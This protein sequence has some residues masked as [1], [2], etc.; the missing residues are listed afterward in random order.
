MIM[1][2]R[3]TILNNENK[4]M[5]AVAYVRVSTE[6]QVLG[7]SLDSQVTACLEYAERVLK[8]DLPLENIFREEGV[9]AKLID[10]PELAKM[11]NHCAKRK[12]EISHCIVWKVDRLARRSEYH[13]VIKAQLLKV[14]VRLVSVTE[15]ISDDPMGNL[16][17]TVLSGFA[18]FDNEIRLIRTTGGMKARTQQGGW[19]H[20]APFGYRKSRTTTGISSIEPDENSKTAKEFL[21]EFNTGAYTVKQM[22]EI[23]FEMGIRNKKGGKKNWQAIKNILGNPLYAGFVRSKY[24][25]G[26]FI[27][28]VHVALISEAT[29]YKNQAIM[30]G[31]FKNH[32]VQAKEKWPL[33]GGFIKHICGKQLTGS[34]T[35][36]GSGPSPRYTCTQCKATDSMQ[37][38]LLRE[39]V[40]QDFLKLLNSVQPKE[41]TQKLYKEVLLRQWNNEFK[42]ALEASKRVDEELAALKAKKSRILDMFIDG[43]ID[44]SDK[45]LKIR[46]TEEQIGKTKLNQIEREAYV[47]EKEKIV[48]GALL[49]MSDPG[50]FWN[51]ANLDLR[52]HI[53]HTVFPNGVTYDFKNGFQNPVPSE[54][55]L[56]QKEVSKKANLSH[57]HVVAA[58]GFEPVTSGL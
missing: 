2:T 24:T 8:I 4:I 50:L 45:D 34:S 31:Q 19:P 40:H 42:N 15:P 32:S 1:A 38:S 43:E 21:E 33:R 35:R 58:T 11:V 47:D 12:G 46:E 25:D 49:F 3:K 16:M 55:F 26:Q 56:L 44:A 14:G 41:G 9:S 22:T 28:G 10:R 23:A 39:V 6:E 18:Q 7:T 20:D 57:P 27:Q 52:K 13:H 30:S 51:V 53:Q 36:G 48:D 17:E 5:Q 29:Y 54:V 37:V